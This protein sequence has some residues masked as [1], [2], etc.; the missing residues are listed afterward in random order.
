MLVMTTGVSFG[1]PAEQN[2]KIIIAEARILDTESISYEVIPD[3]NA[4]TF[5]FV[6]SS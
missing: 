6:M 5:F 3:N 2:K 4:D 1:F